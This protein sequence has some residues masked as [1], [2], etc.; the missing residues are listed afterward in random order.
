M[1]LSPKVDFKIVFWV[2]KTPEKYVPSSRY[3][4]W[5]HKNNGLYNIKR[6]NKNINDSIFYLI[7]THEVTDCGNKVQFAICSKSVDIGFDVHENFI[8]IYNLDKIKAETLFTVVKNVFIKLNL[9]SLNARGQCYD[10]TNNMCVI[11]S[12]VSNEILLEN[13]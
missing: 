2:E 3:A 7:M 6:H 9:P 10:G 13:P 8:G 12:G 4:I 5:N 1:N 11:K